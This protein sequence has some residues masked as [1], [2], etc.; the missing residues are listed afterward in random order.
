MRKPKIVIT[1]VGVALAA[2]GDITAAVAGN[3][4]T[5]TSGGGYGGY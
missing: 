4:P 1:R 2:A 3:V 5:G